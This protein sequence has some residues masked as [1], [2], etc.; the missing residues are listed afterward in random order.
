MYE[1]KHQMKVGDIITIRKT[2][3]IGSM[4]WGKVCVVIEKSQLMVESAMSR[5]EDCQSTDRS[6]VDTFTAMT[7]TGR[8]VRGIRV[9]DIEVEDIE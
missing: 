5:I 3:W 4:Y 7:D 8:L 9:E 6:Y 1:N 2:P